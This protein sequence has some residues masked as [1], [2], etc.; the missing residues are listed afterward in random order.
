MFAFVSPNLTHD[1]LVFQA[2]GDSDV[3]E[4]SA[5]Q[6]RIRAMDSPGKWPLD[7]K[8]VMTFSNLK[9]DV[10]EFVPGKMY[11]YTP[12]VTGEFLLSVPRNVLP[13]ICHPPI[14]CMRSKGRTRS[15]CCS[16]Q[17]FVKSRCSFQQNLVLVGS[18]TGMFVQ[19]F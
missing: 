5:D 1:G 4:L 13:K 7:S 2:M 9:V 3:V 6:Q 10:P 12:Q 8:T 14:E 18:K 17:K 16:T 15:C 19:E 11:H